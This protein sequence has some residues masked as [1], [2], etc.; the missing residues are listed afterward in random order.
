MSILS[1]LC[2]KNLNKEKT[3]VCNTLAL[4]F[5]VG[6]RLHYERP[7]I[8]GLVWVGFWMSINGWNVRSSQD[9]NFQLPLSSGDAWLSY[10][11]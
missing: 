2:G 5:V 8:T 7:V 11:E 10:N 1:I 6:G 9:L 4:R 3:R